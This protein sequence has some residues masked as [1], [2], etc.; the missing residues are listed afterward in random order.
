MSFLPGDLINAHQS[1]GRKRIKL[2]LCQFFQH[3]FVDAVYRFETFEFSKIWLGFHFLPDFS[4]N[5]DLVEDFTD[6]C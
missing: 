2:L 3:G 1:R 5:R 6:A 4:K